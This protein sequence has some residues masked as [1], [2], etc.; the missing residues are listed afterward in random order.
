[1]RIDAARGQQVE[2]DRGDA[3]VQASLAFDLCFFGTVA[4][5]CLVHVFDPQHVGVIGC[6]QFFGLAL[7]ELV[8]FLHSVASPFWLPKI[9]ALMN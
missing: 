5:G 6:V 9:G 2:Q 7:V 3:V 1:M 8:Q 4:G